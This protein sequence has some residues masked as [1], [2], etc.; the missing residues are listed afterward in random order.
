MP[1]EE[2]TVGSL[3]RVAG[4]SA[5]RFAHMFQDRTRLSPRD[6]RQAPRLRFRDLRGEDEPVG[7]IFSNPDAFS[8]VPES[9]RVA[10]ESRSE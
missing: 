4:L 2:V 6:F 9:R 7:W 10:R 5:S 1:D 8:N 3:V